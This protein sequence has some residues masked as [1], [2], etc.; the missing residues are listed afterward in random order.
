VGANVKNSILFKIKKI[1]KYLRGV[2][3]VTFKDGAVDKAIRIEGT[4]R[5]SFFSSFDPSSFARSYYTLS[6]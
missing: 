6:L 1:E 5:R 3:I 4:W 2:G